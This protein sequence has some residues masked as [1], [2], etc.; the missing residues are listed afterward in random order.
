MFVKSWERHKATTSCA[1]EIEKKSRS[2][3]VSQID[4]SQIS[5]VLAQCFL[6]TNLCI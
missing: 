1:C 4:S 2:Y 5:N 6:P 3:M